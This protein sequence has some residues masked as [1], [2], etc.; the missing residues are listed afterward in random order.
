M[1]ICIINQGNHQDTNTLLEDV[2]GHL[3]KYL[4]VPF[5][6]LIE[7]EI[8]SNEPK[9]PITI[10]R[11]H[12]DEPIRVLL[13]ARDQ[14]WCQFVFQFAHEFCHVLTNYYEEFLNNPNLWLHETVCE[15]ASI[16]VLRQMERQWRTNPTSMGQQWYASA[17]QNYANERLARPD[18]Q[19][20]S[21]VDLPGWLKSHENELRISD[22]SNDRQRVNQSLIAYNLLPLFEENPKGWNAITTFPTSNGELSEYL[23]DWYSFVNDDYKKFVSKVSDALGCKV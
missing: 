21:G 23:R 12:R 17:F 14:Y 5:S 15:I 2:V 6:G 18:V 9:A 11:N 3:N 16:F 19:L 13:S 22:V 7:V 1:N 20:P 4:R 10:N 8:A